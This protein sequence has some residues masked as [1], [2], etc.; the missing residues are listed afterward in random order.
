MISNTNDI[1]VGKTNTNATIFN[2]EVVGYAIGLS[3]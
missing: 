3:L 2:F 1:W